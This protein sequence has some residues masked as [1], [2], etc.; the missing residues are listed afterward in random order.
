[1][2]DLALLRPGRFDRQI[3]ID[4]PTL[5]ERKEILEQHMKGVQLDD[6]P[7][8]Y[9]ER[10]AT[11]T[12]GF[13]GADLANLINEAALHAARV[14][15]EKVKKA[16]LE[17]AIERVIAGPEKKSNA[18]SPADREIVAY[19]ESGHAI[20]KKHAF[21]K[22]YDQF[23]LN[24]SCFCFWETIYQLCNFTKFLLQK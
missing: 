14:K 17:Y 21:K 20:G 4:L 1:M 22:K 18:L 19:H 16:D 6:I 9:S 5:I 2:L 15:N 23:V 10:L 8:K 7:E 3:T 24:T 13:S 12:P 11:L